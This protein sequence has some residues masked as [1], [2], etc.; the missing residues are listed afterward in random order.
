M[1]FLIPV[2]AIAI[3]GAGSALAQTQPTPAQLRLLTIKNATGQ[4]TKPPV[5]KPPVV[6]PSPALVQPTA[7]SRPAGR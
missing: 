7:S 5:V 2:L 1:K 4:L 6:K 3:F